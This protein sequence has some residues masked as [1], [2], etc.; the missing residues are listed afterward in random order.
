[1]WNATRFFKFGSRPIATTANGIRIEYSTEGKPSDPPVLLLAGHG[2]TKSQWYGWPRRLARQGFYVISMDSRDSGL[3]QRFPRPRNWAMQL[4]WTSSPPYQVSDMAKDAMALLRNLGIAKAHIVGRS[5]GGLV[6][7]LMGVNFPEYCA[8]LTLIM[9]A[10][11]LPRAVRASLLKHPLLI[12]R[13]IGH[14]SPNRSMTEETFIENRMKLVG[15]TCSEPTC[16]VWIAECREAFRADWRRGGVDWGDEGGSNH[17]LAVL[18]WT[19]SPAF[20]SFRAKLSRCEIPALVV[21]GTDDPVIDVAEGKDLA[22]T[23][24]NSTF[25]AYEGMHD[26]PLRHAPVLISTIEAHLRGVRL[27][28]QPE[29]RLL[30]TKDKKLLVPCFRGLQIEG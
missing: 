15:Y 28:Q 16:P 9:T 18:A 1:M 6:A 2:C 3:S 17:T 21:H 12:S 4:G 24:P 5:M 7:Q 23:L 30:R 19:R 22:R 13:I 11:D 26:L 27:C 10:T 29:T 20:K 25:F 8:S 14:S